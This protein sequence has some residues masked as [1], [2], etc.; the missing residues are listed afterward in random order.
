MKDI[1]GLILAGGRGERMGGVDKGWAI[2]E[3][4]PLIV[5]VVERFAPQVGH[6]LISANRNVERY[7]MLGT[8]VED[9]S[10]GGDRF[11]G[12]LIG[13]L[14]GLRQARTEWVAIVPCDAP[15]LPLDLVQRLVSAVLNAG[16]TAAC[17]R[18]NDQLQPTFTLVKTDSAPDLASAI[19]AGTRAMHRW[20]ESIGVVAVDFDDTTAFANINHI[21]TE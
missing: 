11:A 13:V 18:V 2:H 8:V 4:R 5:T 15:R 19:A 14:S 3:R 17:A 1:T 7:G 21:V 10:I 12:P 20:L 6:L 9:I 16:A